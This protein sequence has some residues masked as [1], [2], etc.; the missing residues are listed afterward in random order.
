[1]AA[2]RIRG[3]TTAGTS[4]SK[5]MNVSASVGSGHL[6]QGSAANTSPKPTG[7]EQQTL[8]THASNVSAKTSPVQTRPRFPT[9]PMNRAQE[10]LPTPRSFDSSQRTIIKPEPATQIGV[11][12]TS[13]AGP[14]SDPSGPE[15]NQDYL[16]ALSLQQELNE[17]DRAG[18]GSV[19]NP[20]NQ[21]PIHRPGE[22]ID[23]TS[24][25]SESFPFDETYRAQLDE[26]MANYPQDRDSYLLFPEGSNVLNARCRTCHFSVA[27]PAEGSFMSSFDT[28]MDSMRGYEVRVFVILRFHLPL[29]FIYFLATFNF[30]IPSTQEERSN[31]STAR[32]PFNPQHTRNQRAIL[33]Q[34]ARSLLIFT[35]T[36]PPNNELDDATQ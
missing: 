9:T 27:L 29:L 1:M 22:A 24:D 5:L 10:A 35:N 21:T 3:P 12:S 30:T 33:S 31:R 34:C 6:R 32:W 7:N 25:D 2:G 13:F 36:R 11:V 4:S 26:I 14:S 19:S 16:F 20:P 28:I 18:E 23:L 17:F 15:V 8:G